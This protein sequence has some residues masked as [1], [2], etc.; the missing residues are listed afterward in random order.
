MDHD[1]Y[2]DRKK[3]SFAQ[4]EGVEPLPPQ[5]ARTEVTPQ[6][7][8]LLWAIIDESMKES[9][10]LRDYDKTRITGPW[11]EILRAKNIVLDHRMADEFTTV[12]DASHKEIK[13][14]FASG[15]YVQIFGFVQWLL[16]RPDCP[17]RSR[18]VQKMLKH[19]RAAYRLLDDGKTFVPI[20]DDT[21]REVLNK[22]F[23]DLTSSEFQ[24][25]RT[26]LRSAA[27]ELTSGSPA[28]SIRE[29]I[30]AVESVA[31]VIGGTK[32]LTGALQRLKSKRKIH[33]AMEQGFGSLYG[34][35]SDE[36]GIRHPL[37]EEDAAN[38]DEADAQFMIGACAA[39]VSYLINR[40]RD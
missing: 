35:S 1:E 21:E 9:R 10:L 13:K 30:H 18:D 37:L 20:S 23:A 7:R 6:L 40:S 33:R 5:L 39:F 24:G 38:V 8:S 22:A 29:S 19:S 31:R 4:A 16:R 14:I 11:D 34:F 28:D 26:H 2:A 12:F 15:D 25:A 27:D 3:L 17:I 32:S 36:K